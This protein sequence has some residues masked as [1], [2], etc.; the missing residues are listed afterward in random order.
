[1][2]LYIITLYLHNDALTICIMRIRCFFT[3]CF[4]SLFCVACSFFLED[5]ETES[6]EELN[7]YEIVV[8]DITS[9]TDKA[10]LFIAGK[11]GSFIM[12]DG[13]NGK[14]NSVLHFG[15]SIENKPEMNMTIILNEDG[16]PKMISYQDY[17]IIIDNL[18]NDRADLLFIKG[19]ESPVYAYDVE[20][21]E[22]LPFELSQT[23]AWYDP[24]V[25]SITGFDW[26][27]WDEHQIKAL[28]PFLLKLVSFGLN[29][30]EAV[31][32]NPLAIASLYY[33]VISEF[34]KSANGYD[35]S[36]VS[37]SNSVFSITDSAWQG[38]FKFGSVGLSVVADGLNSWAD[39]L[40]K[41]MGEYEEDLSYA[42]QYKD[43]QI[44]MEPG[45]QY[46]TGS[47]NQIIINCGPSK[48]VYYVNIKT[49]SF[50]TLEYDDN[51]WCS[52][53]KNVKD[54]GT[55]NIVV[56]VS[57]NT[58]AEDRSCLI[59]V[60]TAGHGDAPDASLYQ[61]TIVVQQSKSDSY[62]TLSRT[63]LAFTSEGGNE[64]VQIVNKS[65]D[66]D[67]W[68]VWSES[69]WCSV[70]KQEGKESF[71]VSVDKHDGKRDDIGY[72]YVS[73]Y[74][75]NKPYLP[76]TVSV[77]VSQET[78]TYGCPDANH[79]HAIDLGLSVKWACC[80]VGASTPDGKGD[81]FA[82]G[83]TKP[84]SV[85]ER[86]NYKWITTESGP[87]LYTKYCTNPSYAFNNLADNKTTLESSDDAASVNWGG[88]WR[89]PTNEEFEELKTNCTWTKSWQ[90]GGGKLT[91]P[92]GN[93]IVLQNQTLAGHTRF[94]TYGFTHICYW[95][96][97]LY[98]TP[99]SSWSIEQTCAYGFFPEY[100]DVGM[101]VRPVQ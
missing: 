36:V 90:Y 22:N 1:M 34:D 54:D 61:G 20:I 50:W 39:Y 40:F 18:D 21:P 94:F 11:D 32:G 42:L 101:A 76:Y 72:V 67:Y 56:A 91:G 68:I 81:L 74:S 8:A 28:F 44:Q 25:Y 99:A 83:E 41:T 77:K 33:T 12:F 64:E 78:K 60:R 80:D 84:K 66:I 13:D 16:F 4:F 24:W 37:F 26:S 49:K 7:N 97:T 15:T 5:E 10:D 87:I 85:Y 93:S 48:G 2:T 92:N 6:S 9:L 73:A 35:D 82:W 63:S 17:Q 27:N 59:H 52:A 3:L 23:R 38:S 79:P 100:R 31:S 30:F 58:E 96:S 51:G 62:F 29:A 65:S 69:A 45:D 55:D 71:V 98:T 95:T 86:E 47:R 57:E 19:N 43:Y 88:G 89:M 53:G 70:T 46:S 14:G 75:K